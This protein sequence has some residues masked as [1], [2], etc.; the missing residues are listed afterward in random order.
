MRL[1]QEIAFE[2]DICAHL[3]AHGWLYEPG[4]AQRYDRARALFPPDL[5]AWVQETQ[6]S[7][8]ETLTKTHGAATETVLLDRIRTQLDDR[9]T[10]DLL[11]HGGELLGLR[12]PLQLAQFKPALAM[13]PALEA[14]Y[15]AN[16][17]RVVRQVHYSLHHENS[18]DLTLFLFRPS[19]SPSRRCGSWRRPRASASP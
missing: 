12:K 19:P 6:P 18:L 2:D 5:I 8:W 16:R 17:L 1:H 9:G 7:A 4:D 13:N 10:L 14:R 11:R 15:Q 3:A